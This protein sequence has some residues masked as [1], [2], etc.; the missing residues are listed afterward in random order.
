MRTPPL[1]RADLE[2]HTAMG[3]KAID[4]Q[5]IRNVTLI[6]APDD[7]AR[8]AHRLLRRFGNPV[9]AAIGWPT[10]GVEHTVRITELSTDTPIA[11]LERS[12]RVADGLI[13][14]VNATA[15][16]APRLR[17]ML[18]VADDHQ[19]ARLCLA[20]ELGHPAASFDRCIRMITDTR[21]A[22]P[23]PLQL[24]LGT[25]PFA[26]LADLLSMR[27]L[28]PPAAERHWALAEQ[29]HRTL[30][31]TVLDP[32]P[33]NSAALPEIPLG[34]LHHRI[35]VL[36]RLGE[37]V[38]VLCDTAARSADLAAVLDTIVRYLPSPL[39]VCQPEHALDY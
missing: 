29:A 4:P 18:R 6:G 7:T 32:A 16:P 26:E 5:S 37:V 23:L 36:T 30:V 3:S 27:P 15:T 11:N 8:V 1:P 31:R 33:A 2:Y 17:T 10:D 28:K 12:I 24:P 35:R 38:P 21:G 39:D 25:A 9:R 13:A 20:I 34:R 22:V 19:V 14:V